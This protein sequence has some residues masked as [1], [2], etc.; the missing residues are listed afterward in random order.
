[1]DRLDHQVEHPAEI[2]LHLR[3]FHVEELTR[4]HATAMRLGYTVEC[5][6]RQPY[7]WTIHGLFM[8]TPDA[9]AFFQLAQVDC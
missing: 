2:V 3:L 4:I 5:D 1:M 7:E 9:E 6:S 8:D